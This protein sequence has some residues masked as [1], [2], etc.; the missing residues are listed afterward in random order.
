MR[1]GNKSLVLLEVVSPDESDHAL[2]RSFNAAFHMYADGGAA[3]RAARNAAQG[4]G[5]DAVS[6]NMVLV[7]M[8]GSRSYARYASDGKL[9]GRGRYGS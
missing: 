8:D 7:K 5:G 2:A 3:V 9:L 6:W 4:L 1:V